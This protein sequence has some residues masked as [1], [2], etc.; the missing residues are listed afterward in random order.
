MGEEKGS[1]IARKC[2]EVMKIRGRAG[3]VGSR[4]KE[5]RREFFE[6]RGV[7]IEEVEARRER[8]GEWFKELEERDKERQRRERWKEIE[9]SK[10]NS[11]R[12]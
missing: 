5:E 3:R 1:E 12:G 8:G 6:E 10:Y 2:L 7:G 9:D 11:P 4:W